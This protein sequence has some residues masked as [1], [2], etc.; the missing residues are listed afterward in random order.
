LR[1]CFKKALEN[2]DVGLSSRPQADS[3]DGFVKPSIKDAFGRDN[4]DLSN[5][6]KFRIFLKI[7]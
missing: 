2:K 6:E 5:C 1:I 7:Q 4:A 3:K